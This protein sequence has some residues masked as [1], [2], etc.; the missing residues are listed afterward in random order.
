M[1]QALLAWQPSDPSA[2]AVLSPWK[3]VFP[4]ATMDALLVRSVVPKLVQ[5]LRALDINP[6]QQQLEPFQWVMVSLRT[7]TGIQ[8]TPPR[9]TQSDDAPVTSVFLPPA[10]DLPP[11]Q[12][13][14]E[15]VSELHFVSL[16]EGE[17]F[18][19]WMHTLYAWLTNSGDAGPDFGE[20]EAW[21]VPPSMR[22]LQ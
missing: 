4:A 8:R 14:E 7:P 16:L 22:V 10:H 5:V 1:R 19:K 9:V 11:P 18:P 17:F 13:W 2:L 15:M 21:C 12:A 20:I 6:R 3:K